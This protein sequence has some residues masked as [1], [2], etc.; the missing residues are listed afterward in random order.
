MML[1][2]LKGWAR[3]LRNQLGETII[4]LALGLRDSLR[5]QLL[6]R[7]WLLASLLALVWLVVFLVWREDVLVASLF[8]GGTRVYEY[9][10]PF[11]KFLPGLHIF[12]SALA[13][14]VS[15]LLAPFVAAGLIVLSFLALLLVSFHWL[16]PR[17]LLPRIMVCVE[18]QYAIPKR[19]EITPIQRLSL[20]QQVRLILTAVLGVAICLLIPVFGILFLLLWIGYLSA[21]SQ[22]FRVLSGSTGGDTSLQL[23]RRSRLPL[24]MIGTSMTLMLLV[25][26][27]GLIAPTAM[28]A[29]VAH[30]M[31][32]L[33]ES[34]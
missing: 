25:P 21:R 4:C 28:T 15:I 6:W 33:Q 5:W 18:R 24:M 20:W 27:F 22:C 19:E 16:A 32:R 7:G 14:G 3:R 30:L 8:F 29:A 11:L 31:K 13:L 9:V 23:L 34:A 1:N 17:S 12:A 10:L 26:I 2:R